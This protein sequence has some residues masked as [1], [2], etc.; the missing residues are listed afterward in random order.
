[1]A[2]P[3]EAAIPTLQE[4]KAL[5][6][7]LSKLSLQRDGDIG[8]DEEHEEGSSKRRVCEKIRAELMWGTACSS[9]GLELHSKMTRGQIIQALVNQSI[10]LNS[11]DTGTL[12]EGF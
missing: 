11:K 2:H 7:R 4:G 12:G 5:S 6:S 8:T 3:G 1:M 9:T 10:L